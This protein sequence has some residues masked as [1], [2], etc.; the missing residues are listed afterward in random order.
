MPS[1]QINLAEIPAVEVQ[2]LSRTFLSAVKRFYA[3]PR[4]VQDFEKWKC[5]RE[6]QTSNPKK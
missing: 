3:D 2:N 1:A 4:H 5:Q 6:Q